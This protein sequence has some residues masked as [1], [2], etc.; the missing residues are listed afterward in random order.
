MYEKKCENILKYL[1]EGTF[2][3]CK[4]FFWDALYN[5]INGA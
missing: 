3:K 5:K 4:L 1:Y 2:E